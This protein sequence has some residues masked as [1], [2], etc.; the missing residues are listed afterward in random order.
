[1]FLNQGTELTSCDMIF[2]RDL[3]R[4]ANEPLKE[5]L[6]LQENIAVGLF[7]LDVKLRDYGCVKNSYRTSSVWNTLM[8]HVDVT[9]FLFSNSSQTRFFDN[10]SFQF[11]L[12]TD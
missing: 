7:D 5:V 1:M 6:H 12:N 3:P 8:T 4:D 10:T 9:I 2:W 11:L